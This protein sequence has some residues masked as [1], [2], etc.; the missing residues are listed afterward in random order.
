MNILSITVNVVSS[1]V[2]RWKRSPDSSYPVMGNC[3]VT[4]DPSYADSNIVVGEARA[5]GAPTA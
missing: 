4:D 5:L 3:V 2:C 1:N